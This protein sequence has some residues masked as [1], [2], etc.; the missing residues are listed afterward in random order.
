MGR[1]TGREAEG[2]AV[3]QALVGDAFGGALERR[4]HPVD[5]P[6]VARAKACRVAGSAGADVV[7]AVEVQVDRQLAIQHERDGIGDAGRSRARTAL[8]DIDP[9]I[10]PRRN[11]YPWCGPSIHTIHFRLISSQS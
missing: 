1:E 8:G 10:G 9:A 7:F 11:R 2:A 3:D 5:Q 4:P 6:F